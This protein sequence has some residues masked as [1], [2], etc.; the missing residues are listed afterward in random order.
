MRG[1]F[2]LAWLGALRRR[3]QAEGRG[4]AVG[5]SAVGHGRGHPAVLLVGFHQGFEGGLGFLT[6]ESFLGLSWFPTYTTLGG[7]K[8][9]TGER[10]SESN[11]SINDIKVHLKSHATER[12]KG[13]IDCI[14]AKPGVTALCI[15]HYVQDCL[16][17]R[18]YRHY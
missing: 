3:S 17:G 5:C 6:V 12:T 4:S 18:K 1:F 10:K 16:S 8:K 15:S 14:L 11:R 2:E 9:Q 7:G 13:T